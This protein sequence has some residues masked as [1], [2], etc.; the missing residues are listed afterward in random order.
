M[1]LLA[2]AFGELVVP[3]AVIGELGSIS[4]PGWLR[5]QNPAHP[6]DRRLIAAILG[7]AGPM[8]CIFALGAIGILISVIATE[9]RLARE[10]ARAPGAGG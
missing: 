10:Q 5:E 2:G 8:L 9:I 3:G 4:V 6:L 1:D 7:L